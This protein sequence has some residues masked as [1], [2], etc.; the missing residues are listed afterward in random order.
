[1]IKTNASTNHHAIIDKYHAHKIFFYNEILAVEIY[2]IRLL[3][4]I[5]K[6]VLYSYEI[7]FV[8]QTR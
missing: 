7:F 3:H 6:N 5:K 4:K 8:H 2:V 1:M